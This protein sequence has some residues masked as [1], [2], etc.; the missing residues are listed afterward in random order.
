MPEMQN[1]LPR[2]LSSQIVKIYQ[3][4]NFSKVMVAEIEYTNYF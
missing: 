3:T 1:K 4:N 2:D